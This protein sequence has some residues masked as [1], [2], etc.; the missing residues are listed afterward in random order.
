MPVICKLKITPFF[1]SCFWSWRLSQI[2]FYH[3]AKIPQP[4][5]PTERRAYLRIR[6]PVGWEYITVMAEKHGRKHQQQTES[7][8][9]M[10][11]IFKL[12][13][14]SPHPLNYTNRDSSWVLSIQM[15][16]SLGDYLIQTTTVFITAMESNLGQGMYGCVCVGVCMYA[17]CVYAN[18]YIDQCVYV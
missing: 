18:I 10:V 15:S 11:Q 5:K 3:Y 13:P 8:L 17:L 9:K 14:T 1:P 2:L 12:P 7:K 4:R 6:V 16:E